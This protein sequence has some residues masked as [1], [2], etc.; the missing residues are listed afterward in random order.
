MTGIAAFDFEESP[1]RAFEREDGS[2]WF[3]AKDVCRALE[4]RNHNDAVAKLAED[5]KDGVG[6]ADRIGRPQWITTISEA[7]LY[8]LIFTSRKPSAERFRQWVFHEVL[9][10]I[11]RTGRFGAAAGPAPLESRFLLSLP[12]PRAMSRR[13][14]NRI[15]HWRAMHDQ[16]VAV[17]IHLGDEIDGSF[18]VDLLGRDGVEQD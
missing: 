8:R 5:E 11:R 14:E 4:I 2:V 7:G 1:V 3:A 12:M 15:R 9:P 16:A 18:A 17:L 10:A 6:I 13:H